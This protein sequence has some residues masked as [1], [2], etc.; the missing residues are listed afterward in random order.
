MMENTLRNFALLPLLAMAAPAFAQTEPSQP[1]AEAGSAV[2]DD[3]ITS[4][5]DSHD[6]VVIAT[7]L[8]GQVDTPQPPLITLDAEDIA[9]YGASS[10]TELIESLGTQTSS[11]RGRGD[12]FPI[13]LINGQR[14]SSFREMRNLP[15]EAIRRMEVLPEE[16]AL[17]FGYPPNQRVVNMILKDNFASKTVELEY[18]RPTDGGFDIFNAEAS[19]FRTAGKSRLNLT[20]SADDTSPLTESERGVRQQTPDNVA[21]VPTDLNPGDFRTLVA[22]SKNFG[23]NGT[24]TAPLG[25]GANAA[26][27]TLNAAASRADTMSFS[28]LPTV[29][30]TGP[31]ANPSSAYR[32]IPDPLMRKSRTDTYQAGLN[33]NKGLGE[34]RM[35]ATVD[36]TTATTTTLIDRRPSATDLASLQSAA[37][38][39]TLSITGV[40]PP[41]ADPGQ[42]RA[43]V[44]NNSVTSLVTLMGRPFVMPAGDVSATLKG[45]FA[46]TGLNSTDTRTGGGQVDLD[47]GDLSAGINVGIPL[48]SRK[49]NV[50]GG[51]GDLSLNLSGGIDRLSDFGTLYDYSVGLTWGV[52]D[53]LS[54]QASYIVNEAAPTLA[55]LGNPLIVTDNVA[56]FDFNRNETALVTVITGGNR[57]LKQEVQRDLKLSANWQL[58]FLK[59]SSFLVEYIRNN[60]DD[61]T[62]AFPVLT[63]AIEA[64]FPGRVVRNGSGQLISI[65]QRPVTFANEQSSRLR[66]GFNINGTIGKA[67]PPRQ[68]GFPGMGGARGP[69]GPGGPGGGFGGP[70][71]GGGGGFGGP[72]GGGFRGPGG[73]GGAGG[74][75]QGRW[76]IAIYHTVRFDE[77]VLVA[78]GGPSLDLLGGDALSGGGVSRH[79]LEIEGGAFYKGTGFRLNGTWSAPTEVRGS[80]MLGTSDLRFGSLFKLNLRVFANLEQQKWL[81][82]S[83]SFFKGAR[84]SLSVDN[85]LNSRQRVT[86]G[87]G[88]VPISYQ[89]DLIDPRGR[90]IGLELRKQF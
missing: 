81:V 34:W 73:P 25:S 5:T 44:R 40:L 69:G 75:Q 58:P 77:T 48:T 9:S 55:N 70:R 39:G 16:V 59:N 62:A 21:L 6:I 7:R 31:G 19:L 8:A 23:F 28:G 83:S 56:V 15:P 10:V 22:N 89:P 68:G 60:S 57:D 35:T 72:G 61:V 38:A 32:Y 17:K 79:A 88:Q 53:K 85:L 14:I 49:N 41:L 51:I 30:L 74:Q 80:T 87:T 84:L 24:W 2:P 47:R 27:L 86:D 78:P 29:T 42:D 67:P 37:T 66:Y 63:P 50:L 18:S 1:T 82:D 54:L 3:E 71:G 4:P 76:N 20:V 64:A 33:L 45:G 46:Y 11:S 90:V 65:D 12:G 13:M 36:A 52:T 43:W 26:G